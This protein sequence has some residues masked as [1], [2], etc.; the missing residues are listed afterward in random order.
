ME[1]NSESYEEK[2]EEVRETSEAP[3]ESAN[4]DPGEES[5][6]ADK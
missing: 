4:G 6:A 1:K 2:A 5:E 3:G